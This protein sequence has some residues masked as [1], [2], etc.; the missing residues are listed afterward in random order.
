MLLTRRLLYTKRCFLFSVYP[1]SDTILNSG[2][3]VGYSVVLH[4]EVVLIQLYLTEGDATLVAAFTV[5]CQCI[6]RLHLI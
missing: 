1:A 5:K 3:G 2:A 6:C 4:R